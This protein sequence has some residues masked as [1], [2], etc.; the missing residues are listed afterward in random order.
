[1]APHVLRITNGKLHFGFREVTADKTATPSSWTAR[2][3]G[4]PISLCERGGR[5]GALPG[6]LN[7]EVPCSGNLAR[8]EAGTELPPEGHHHEMMWT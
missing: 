1:M 7:C 5:Q 4:T 6:L 2:W 8:Q 3:S